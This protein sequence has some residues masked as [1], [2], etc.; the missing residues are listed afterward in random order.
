M[1]GPL[2]PLPPWLH[3]VQKDLF[4]LFLTSYI[5]KGEGEGKGKAFPLQAWTGPWGFLESEALEFLDNRH[6]K[7]VRLSALRTGRLYPQEGFLV[8]ISVRGWVDP[9]ATMRPEGLSHWKFS[10][11]SIGNRTR[12]LR[13]CS[14]MPQPTAPTRTP[15]NERKPNERLGKLRDL[16]VQF[17]NFWISARQREGSARSRWLRCVEVSFLRRMAWKRSFYFAQ[18]LCWCCQKGNLSCLLGEFFSD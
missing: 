15:P 6:M 17:P 1:S 11:D 3:G 9:R 18:S 10:S 5:S 4:F 8:L 7:V 2:S 13:A 12:D 14:A 16:Y